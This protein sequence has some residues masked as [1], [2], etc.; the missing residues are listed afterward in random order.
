MDVSVW[1]NRKIN[2]KTHSTTYKAPTN[3]VTS[4]LL[5]YVYI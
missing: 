5:K 2:S 1:S 3:T 4:S